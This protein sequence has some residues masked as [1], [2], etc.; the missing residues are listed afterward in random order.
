MSR[1]P[2]DLVRLPAHCTHGKTL[3]SFR[4][5]LPGSVIYD[6]GC[7]HPKK[8]ADMLAHYVG[9]KGLIT[10]TEWNKLYGKGRR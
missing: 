3:K 1:P 6:P 4:A 5:V 7:R 9:D 8:I 2:S 10:K